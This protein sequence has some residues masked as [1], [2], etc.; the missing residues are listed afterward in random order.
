MVYKIN[1]KKS[2]TIFSNIP[3]TIFFFL[4]IYLF[5]QDSNFAEQILII[6]LPIILFLSYFTMTFNFFRSIKIEK[7][8]LLLHFGPQL[9]Y[10]K[11]YFRDMEDIRYAKKEDYIVKGQ[12]AYGFIEKTVAIT[13]KDV[14]YIC[15]KNI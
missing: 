2:F 6:F 10:K 7:N 12:P 9:I 13:F 1:I 11:Y 5:I 14:I 3:L 8:N 4:F 15:G